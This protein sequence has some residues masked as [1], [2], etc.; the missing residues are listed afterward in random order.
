MSV[1]VDNKRF[2][3]EF[4]TGS[5]PKRDEIC[6][7]VDEAKLKEVYGEDLDVS[8]IEK[9]WCEFRQPTYGDA[10]VFLDQ[11]IKI[12]DGNV[13]FNPGIAA[14]LKIK[15]LLVSWSFVDDK[16]V[17]VP[18]SSASIE[19]LRPNVAAVIGMLL[20]QRLG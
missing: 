19:S 1:F 6:C 13:E 2:R 10:T 8:T 16:G 4:V 20:E 5:L 3:I 17:A 12:K 18:I 9:H 14:L 11:S 7:D 15:R